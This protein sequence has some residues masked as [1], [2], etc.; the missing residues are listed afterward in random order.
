VYKDKNKTCVKKKNKYHYIID[1]ISRATAK[2]DREIATCVKR[3]LNK[4]S[5]NK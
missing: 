3:S 5:L 2:A 1:I 4:S